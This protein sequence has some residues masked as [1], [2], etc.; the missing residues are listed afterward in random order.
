MVDGLNR[1]RSVRVDYFLR[2]D[3]LCDGNRPGVE[4]LESNMK[5]LEKGM[6]PTRTKVRKAGKAA[7]NY[8]E[9]VL[10]HGDGRKRS[11][12]QTEAVYVTLG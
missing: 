3:K 4:R 7:A 5:G 12:K 8:V 1:I 9:M 2:N 10:L 6:D 11:E